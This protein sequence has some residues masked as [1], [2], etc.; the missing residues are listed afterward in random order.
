MW[1]VWVGSFDFAQDER[2]WG[3]WGLL[4]WEGRLGVLGRIDRWMEGWLA[5]SYACLFA[6]EA[7]G[8]EVIAF[9]AE[10]VLAD[11]HAG[12][13]GEVVAD[14][15]IA[16]DFEVGEAGGAPV[17]DLFGVDRGIGRGVT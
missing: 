13:A 17:Y 15:E 12:G 1:W 7:S 5:D 4:S 14:L 8:G 3:C 2:E 10:D 16:G 6:V 11:A 9:A